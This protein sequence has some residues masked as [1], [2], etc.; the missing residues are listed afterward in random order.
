MS[1]ACDQISILVGIIPRIKDIHAVL[2]TQSHH[3]PASTGHSYWYHTIHG[4]ITDSVL[5]NL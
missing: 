2:I 1:M 5:P 4:N 3:V